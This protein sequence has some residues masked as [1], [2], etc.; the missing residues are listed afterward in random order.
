MK[1]FQPIL[2]LPQKLFYGQKIAI[3]PQLLA[4]SVVKT[5][6]LFQGK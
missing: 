3:L 6:A 2:T 5:A 4:N 1:D